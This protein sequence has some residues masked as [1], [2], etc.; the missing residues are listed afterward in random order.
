MEEKRINMKKFSKKTKK[1]A[2]TYATLGVTAG[3]TAGIA[4]RA[5]HGTPSMTAG[6]STMAS[7]APVVGTAVMGGS[8]LNL[9]KKLYKKKKR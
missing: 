2:S 5:P 3:I 6:F 1:L 7:F 9:T 4:A 8:V